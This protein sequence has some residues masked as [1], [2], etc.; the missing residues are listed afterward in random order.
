MLINGQWREASAN[1]PTFSPSNPATGA[2]LVA[3]YPFASQ[4]EIN[5]MLD[6]GTAAAAELQGIAPAKIADFLNAYADAIEANAE[7]LAAMANE[8]TG[9]PIAPRLTGVEIPRTTGQLRQAAS[10]AIAEEW[11]N[12]VIDTVTNLRSRLESLGKPVLVIGPNNFPFAFNGIAGG[13]FAAAVATGHPVIAKAHPAHPATTKRLTEL[14]LDAAQNTGLPS[15]MVQM[16]YHMD[17]EVGANLCA[18][19]RLGAIGFTGS[20]ATG[21]KIKAAADGSGIPVYLEMSSIN[22]VT[23]LPG[24][25]EA[26]AESLAEEFAGSCLLGVG[27]FCTNPGLVLTVAGAQTETFIAKATEAFTAATGGVMLT[28]ELPAHLESGVNHLT[29]QGAELLARGVESPEAGARGRPALLRV[30]GQTFLA[31]PDEFQSEMF[32]PAS[33]LVVAADDAELLAVAAQLHASLTCSFYT[34]EDGSDDALYE[35]LEPIV[36]QKSGR[37][38]NDKMPTGVAVSPAMVHGGPFPAGGHP[39]FTAVGIPASLRRFGALKCYD[40]VRSHRLPASLR[41]QN[42]TGQLWRY[43]DRTWTQSDV[44]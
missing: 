11:S 37:I 3:A 2:K 32:G 7:A 36:A 34:A 44:A 1:A 27:Q 39:G 40:N 20:E 41:D 12:P 16:F 23:F 14:A 31:Q 30:S 4:D 18:D 13:D 22:P 19:T 9:L 17:P 15:A 28:P 26:K 42:P 33:L 38:L 24:A 29:D 25:I 43:I 10:A 6:A 5:A 21:R 8:E 35:K